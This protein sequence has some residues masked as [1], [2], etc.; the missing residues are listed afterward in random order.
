MWITTYF[1]T[2]GTPTEGLSPIVRVRDVDAGGIVVA[3]GIMSDLGDGI[4][5]YEFTG[6][7]IEGEYA[8][9]CDAITLP[10]VYRYKHLASGEYGDVI[11]T[12]NI[13]GDNVEFRTTLLKKIMTNR[14][15][16]VDGG[17]SPNDANWILY[18]DDDSTVLATWDVTDKDDT[19]IEQEEYTDA[20]R[21]KG[22]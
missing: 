3:S 16:L 13:I 10:D 6:Y 15:E 20:K 9:L 22:V 18:D 5:T 17:I 1:H 21:S 19:D 4:Y 11:D 14:I 12:V 8:I 7:D 2:S